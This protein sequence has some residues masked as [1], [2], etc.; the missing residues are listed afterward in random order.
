M[1][2]HTLDFHCFHM[3]NLAAKPQFL[4]TQHVCSKTQSTAS[5]KRLYA[6]E[7][8]SRPATTAAAAGTTV[9]SAK[10]RR[11]AN[12]NWAQI[13]FYAGDN[14]PPGHAQLLGCRCALNSRSNNGFSTTLL[15][16]AYGHL[17]YCLFSLS[18]LFA[19][20]ST[21][22]TT[23]YHTSGPSALQSGYSSFYGCSL[24]SVEISDICDTLWQWRHWRRQ[25]H[26]KS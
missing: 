25:C 11:H 6:I 23:L 14:L 1:H 20:P 17:P 12:D 2:F 9:L 3:E 21:G 15:F 19:H 5:V 13:V 26:L 10:A 18:Q 8:V 22:H 24:E 7:N 4:E 16:T